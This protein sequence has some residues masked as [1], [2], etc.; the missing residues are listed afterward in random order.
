MESSSS[1]LVHENRDRGL[2][3]ESQC[4]AACTAFYHSTCSYQRLE[5]CQQARRHE[6]MIDQRRRGLDSLRESLKD[7]NCRT[8]LIHELLVVPPRIS[9]C[10]QIDDLSSITDDLPILIQ[11]HEPAILLINEVRDMY[12]PTST[13]QVGWLLSCSQPKFVLQGEHST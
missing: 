11:Q 8:H 12:Q 4:H 1:G 10:T 3:E 7:F 13:L 9:L 5:G 2:T 6:Q